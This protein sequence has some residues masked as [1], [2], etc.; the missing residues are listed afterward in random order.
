MLKYTCYFGWCCFRVYMYLVNNE[1]RCNREW[2]YAYVSSK[3][4][5]ILQT[6]CSI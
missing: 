5:S 1:T 3:Q 2:H 4:V 6:Y